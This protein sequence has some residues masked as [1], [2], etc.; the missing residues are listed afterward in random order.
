MIKSTS[1]HWHLFCGVHAEIYYP[2]QI[3]CFFSRTKVQCASYAIGR[4]RCSWRS[5]VSRIRNYPSAVK[6]T[7]QLHGS[8]VII[9]FQHRPSYISAQDSIILTIHSTAKPSSILSVPET[10]DDAGQFFKA[11]WPEDIPN[12]YDIIDEIRKR[13]KK[14][15][16]RKSLCTLTNHYYSTLRLESTSRSRSQYRM[17]SKKL[18]KLSFVLGNFDEFQKF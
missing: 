3:H 12:E 6:E 4:F 14:L 18:L 10:L 1:G 7:T 15:F 16:Q 9:D 5:H 17:P 2:D 8:L 11:S 13:T